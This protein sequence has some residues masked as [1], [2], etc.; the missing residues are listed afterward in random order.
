VSALKFSA[1]LTHWDGASLA[2]FE[3]H[4]G[5]MTRVYPVW[6]LTA[7]DGL[8]YRRPDAADA[9]RDRVR[10]AAA[11]AGVEVWPL[12][13]NHNPAIG[14]F[15]PAITRLLVSDAKARAVH[16]AGLLALVR[17]DGAQGVDLDYENLYDEDRDAFSAF[18]AELAKVFH[19]AGLKVGIAVHAK[20]SEPGG[21]G[22]SRAQDYGAL[23]A[24]CDRVQVMG[25]DYH[26]SDGEPGPIAPPLWCGAV[27]DHALTRL[28]L[29]KLEWG[30][31]G[32][33]NDWGGGVRA[34]GMRWPR[35]EELVRLHAPARRDPETAELT[36]RYG[37]REVWM[38][39]AISVTAKLWQVR[40]R[41]VA[42][43]AMWVLGAE[44]PRLWA[45]LDTL[46][47]DFLGTEAK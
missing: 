46:P 35:W 24:A 21:P 29:G 4:A 9:L 23:A 26:W 17:E 28:P 41:G 7:P 6:Y 30:I 11:G 25:Y 40:T 15:D 43:V 5:L 34:Q 42:D 13:S 47:G 44:D 22:G 8:P 27:L 2:S 37:D 19:S 1:W 3:A 18:I 20:E 45:L 32:Y 12:I 16:I 33:G 14:N 10:A 36:L 38:N 39:D 31:P